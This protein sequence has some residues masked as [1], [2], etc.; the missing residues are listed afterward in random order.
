MS[1]NVATVEWNGDLTTGS[2]HIKGRTGAVDAAYSLKSRVENTPQTNPEELIGAAHAACYSM[3]VSALLTGAG[4]PPGHIKTVAKVHLDKE[5]EGFKISTIEIE[6]EAK[7]A[8]IDD[9]KFQEVAK[10]AKENC[11]V[12]KALTGVNITL[13]A[14][15]LA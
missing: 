12:S 10:N 7:V 9:A 6:T 13:K 3:M 14:T 8:G 2:G 11:P 4:T 5:G 1:I 15:F